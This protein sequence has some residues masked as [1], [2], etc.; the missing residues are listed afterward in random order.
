VQASFK[1]HLSR[2]RRLDTSA[3]NAS[4]QLRQHERSIASADKMLDRHEI[5]IE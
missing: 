4:E 2:I 1:E 5:S 3:A